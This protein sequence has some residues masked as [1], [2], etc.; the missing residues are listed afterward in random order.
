MIKNYTRLA[1]RNL[2]RNKAF[3]LTNLTG[4]T[5]GITCTILILLWVQ[6]ELSY[7]KFQANYSSI[8]KVMANR[9]FNG[10][11]ITDDVMVFPLAP[12]LAD[13]YPQIKNAVVTSGQEPHILSNGQIKLRK[14]GYTVSA[15][16]FQLF[17]WNFKSGNPVS[18][19][20]D[21]TSIVLTRSA[22]GALFGNEN[23]MN[24]TVRIDDN[25][26]FKVS[27][28]IEDI[29]D[30][31][32]LKF[33]YIIPYD[34]SLDG[35]KRNMTEWTNSSWNIYFQTVPGTN[36]QE[37]NRK[38]N[39]IKKKNS[40]NDKATAYFAFPMKK[41]H[42]YSDFKDGR[43]V[44]G[45]IKYVRLFSIIGIIVLL[46]ACV[47]FMN[48]STARSERRAKEIGVR[49]TLGSSKKQ[50]VLQFFFESIVLVLVAFVLSVGFIH[51]LLPSIN[52]LTH[53]NLVIPL[54]QPFFWCMALAIICFTGFAAGSYP[55]LYLA[56]LNPVNV[57]KGDS[58]AGKRAITP[59]RILIV[60]QFAASIILIGSTIII[61]Q[62][63]HYG[64]HL[65]V[66]YN[67]D[68]LIMIPTSSSTQKNF[69]AIKN[70]LLQTGDIKGITRTS[71]PITEI[72]WKTPCPDWQGKPANSNLV[73]SG[74][75]AELDFT[76][77]MGIKLLAG[78]D[79]S[80]TPIDSSRML[81]NRAAVAI[82]GLKNPVGMQMKHHDKTYFV[83]GIV[84]NVVMESPYKPVDP[85]MIINMP[86]YSNYIAIRLNDQVQPQKA[87]RSIERVFNK[88][89]PAFPF[90]YQFADEEFGKKFLAEELIS[91]V[92]NVFA[93]LAI[94]ISCIGL[95][96][97]VSFTIEKK[98]RE[99]GVRKVLGASVLQ[100]L[101]LI[102]EEFISLVLI[103]FLI[104][105]PVTWWYMQNWL[106]NYDYH[107]SIS[108]WM[109]MG[110]GIFILLLTLLIVSLNTIK[111]AM[112]NP[113]KSL[114]TE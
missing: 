29:S 32:S 8:Y 11:I 1:F 111:A 103:A 90:E 82:M 51:L 93:I 22:A 109:F 86:E 104:A 18:A 60:T 91:K 55:S 49:K 96:G 99:I 65:N 102:S 4:L 67:P 19:I 66:G 9:N 72:W 113:V 68:N 61:Y 53:K 76:K 47:N 50:L 36:L 114:R 20:A 94:F 71:S 107:I 77:T 24:K 101:G 33:D 6:S 10:Q 26:N 81:L 40:P 100:I 108:L 59:R 5:I 85:M 44:G 87:L 43:N 84:D 92:I 112:A 34:Y 63:I 105:V 42:L 23:P 98:V 56:S 79:F 83:S 95:A 14:N 64:K 37:L 38:I 25:V 80:G 75:S 110:V 21:P 89:N 30:N 35:V 7:D 45:M 31:S 73:F 57:L 16:F 52:S 74:M 12:A 39:E 13:E 28:I 41:W 69:I 27:A 97:L 106:Q 3:A 58:R 88:Y 62:Q 48:F 15:Q 2:F 17:S 54:N 70:D 46:I 78:T